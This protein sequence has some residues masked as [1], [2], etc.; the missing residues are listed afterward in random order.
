MIRLQDDYKHAVK[1]PMYLG[2]IRTSMERNFYTSAEDCINDF[3]TMFTNCYR[4]YRVGEQFV[5]DC[6]ELEKAFYTLLT[7]M[8]RGGYY[9]P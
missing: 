5:R 2:T 4:Y 9:V 8:Q 6:Q 1:T 7:T 3:N